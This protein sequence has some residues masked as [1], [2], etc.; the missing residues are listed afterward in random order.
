MQQ[1]KDEMLA[2]RAKI[3]EMRRQRE[4]RDKE[5]ANRGQGSEGASEVQTSETCWIR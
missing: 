2:K 4:L 5:K 3:A 1:R